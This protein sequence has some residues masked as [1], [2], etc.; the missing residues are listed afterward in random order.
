MSAEESDRF[1]LTGAGLPPSTPDWVMP[2]IRRGVWRLVLTVLV[3]LI[4]AALAMRARMVLSI[5]AIALFFGIAMEP[6]V[7][8]LHTR[9]RMRRGLATTLVFLLLGGLLAGIGFILIPGLVDVADQLRRSLLSI[10]P[11]INDRLGTSIPTS[12]R[13]PRW[14]ELTMHVRN[15]VEHHARDVAGFAGTVVGLV[16]Q[17]S[18]VAMFSFYFAVDAPRIRRAVLSRFPAQVQER[19][20]WSWDTAIQQTGG[21]FYSRL[22]LMVVNGGL[23]F[24]GLLLVGIRWELALPLSIFESFLAEFIPAVGTY[25]GAA[26]PLLVV[27]GLKGITAALFMLGWAVFYQ[28]LENYLLS[29]RISART[30]E[31]NG[32]VA[33]GAALTGGAL[34]GPVGAFV[35]LPVAALVTSFVKNYVRRYPVVYE[36]PYDADPPPRQKQKG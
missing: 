24:V 19:L 18:A 35:A 23:F 10:V 2:V 5:L 13:D 4:V 7:N 27:L 6:A 34:A 3:V 36:S 16:F 15:W 14:A 9:A 20:G 11:T 21:Y 26:V 17:A 29:P 25:I 30:M 31:L 33:F 8:M 1:E 28:Q 12:E 32:G 22:I